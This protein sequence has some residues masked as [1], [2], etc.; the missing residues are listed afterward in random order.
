LIDLIFV[1]NLRVTL[2]NVNSINGISFDVEKSELFGL[3]GLN[4]AGKFL[5]MQII[6]AISQRT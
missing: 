4:R 6:I 2:Y 3:L 5:T 1:K